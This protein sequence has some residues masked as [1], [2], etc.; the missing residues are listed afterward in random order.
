MYGMI[1]I[2]KKNYKNGF[3]CIKYT[4]TVVNFM[5]KSAYLNYCRAFNSAGNP[6][7]TREF[8]LGQ[9]CAGTFLI[10]EAVI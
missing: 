3:V 5:S 4:A 2:V 8:V 7:E 1:Y 10:L 9:G 6:E